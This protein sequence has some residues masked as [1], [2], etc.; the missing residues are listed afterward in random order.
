MSD[1]R[2]IDLASLAQQQRVTLALLRAM[3]ENLSVML[4][5]LRGA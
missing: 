4:A 3:R 2:D 1:G 5:E